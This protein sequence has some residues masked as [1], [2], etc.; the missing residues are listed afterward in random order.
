M[1]IES[2]DNIPAPSPD[3]EQRVREP[4][5]EPEKQEETPPPAEEGQERIVDLFA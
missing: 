2:I 3:T 1:A 4:A 5:P